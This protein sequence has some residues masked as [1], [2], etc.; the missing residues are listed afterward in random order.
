MFPRESVERVDS[1]NGTTRAKVRYSANARY[2]GGWIVRWVSVSS[3]PASNSCRN[4]STSSALKHA[5]KL[6]T[7]PPSGTSARGNKPRVSRGGGGGKYEPSALY[8]VGTT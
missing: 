4:S 6:R 8:R 2:S 5:A 3:K 7:T 1:S